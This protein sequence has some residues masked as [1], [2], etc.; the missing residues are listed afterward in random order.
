MDRHTLS[1]QYG[2]HTPS[3]SRGPAGHDSIAVVNGMDS[4][5]QSARS[6]PSGSVSRSRESMTGPG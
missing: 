3:K 5:A 2:P 4:A 1:Y 6:I